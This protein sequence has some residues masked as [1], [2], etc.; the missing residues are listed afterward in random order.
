MNNWKPINLN[1]STVIFYILYHNNVMTID[2]TVYCNVYY[3]IAC[4]YIYTAHGYI[5]Y[6]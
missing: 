3:I 5:L 2:I 4:K 6:F 1:V